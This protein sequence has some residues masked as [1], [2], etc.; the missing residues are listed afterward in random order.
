M[1][2]PH[3]GRGAS[4]TARRREAD[5]AASYAAVIRS[6][7]DLARATFEHLRRAHREQDLELQGRMLC[8][9]MRPRFLAQARA[10]E[11][12]R[13]SR[14][15]ALL[16]ER[17]GDYLLAS[18]HRLDL[19][20]A[21]DQERDIWAVDP[22]YPGLTVTSR[23][24]SF[25]AGSVPRFVEYN[26]ESPASIGFCDCLSEIFL[27]SPAMLAWAGKNGPERYH[28]RRALLDALRWAYGEWGGRGAPVIAIVDWDDVLTK[29]DFELCA[30]YFCAQGIRTVITDPR[31][32]TYRDGAVF[33]GEERI[34]LVYRRVLLHELLARADEAEPLLRAYRDGAIC[35]VNNPRSKLLHK[36]A[37]FALLSDERLGLDVSE[38][39]RLVVDA[40]VPW[41]RLVVEGPTT[42]QGTTTELLNLLQ[43]YPDRFALK[44]VDDY[45]GR[46]VTLGWDTEPDT[47]RTAVENACSKHYVVQER[48]DV[49]SEEFPAWENDELTMLSMLVDTDPLLFRGEM[50][51]ILTRISGDPLLNVTA[52][53][54][55]TTPTF[56][57]PTEER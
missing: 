27:A 19:I 47:W 33:H 55:S 3:A 10:D 5:V 7:P 34:T 32:L 1:E 28:V 2:R 39:E 12:R 31:R 52:G 13:V 30:E 56:V 17:A 42:Y 53:T 22:G 38:E 8:N 40:C 18:D 29:R 44:P 14:V 26:A 51:G 48:V 24:D 16:L 49:P 45:G 36:K 43:T 11:L 21:S 50:G 20:G 37:V 57:V 46:G 25:M 54:G 41:T 15:L 9:V 35:M 6:V 4:A 23:L